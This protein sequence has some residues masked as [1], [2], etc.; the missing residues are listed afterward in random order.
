MFACRHATHCFLLN[1]NLTQYVNIKSVCNLLRIESA[2]ADLH[3]PSMAHFQT[4]EAADLIVSGFVRMFVNEHVLIPSEIMAMLAQWLDMRL[5]FLE[6]RNAELEVEAV[7]AREWVDSV[8]NR[9]VQLM[10]DKKKMR[11]RLY[12]MEDDL[13]ALMESKLRLAESAN[14]TI[15]EL[16]RYLVEYQKAVGTNGKRC[17]QG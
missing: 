17:C 7:R 2:C 4:V 5:Y 16:R 1:C 11:T 12:E 3:H 15:N 9:A 13:Y 6:K 8:E 10:E 14:N